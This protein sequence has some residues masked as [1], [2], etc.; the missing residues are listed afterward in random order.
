MPSCTGLIFSGSPAPL[1]ISRVTTL[2]DTI[3]LVIAGIGLLPS[4]VLHLLAVVEV[5]AVSLDELVG[6]ASCKASKDVFGHS[7]VF[8]DTWWRM[9]LGTCKK[10]LG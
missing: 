4:I 5:L 10:R 2:I 9:V 3:L 7:V 1:S 8:G 6:F